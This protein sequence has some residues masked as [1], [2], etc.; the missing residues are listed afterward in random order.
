VIRNDARQFV[1]KA[2]DF[3]QGLDQWIGAFPQEAQQAGFARASLLRQ[4]MSLGSIQRALRWG[5]SVGLYGESQCG[6]S[7]LVSR[8]ASGLG[9]GS[10]K[11]GSLLIQDPTPPA[12]RAAQPWHTPGTDGIEFASWIDPSGGKEATGIVCRFTRTSLA[13]VEPGHF[14]VELMSH[15]ELASSL[16]LG[17]DAEIKESGVEGRA[18][19][20]A[21]TLKRLKAQPREP[22]TGGTMGE[23]L[24]A[25]DFLNK[26]EILG[27]HA[28]FR[29]LDNGNDGWDDFARDC[30]SERRRPRFSGQADESDL[31]EFVGLLWD[32]V[33][34][35]TRLW[36]KLYSDLRLVR[37]MRS[38]SV[39]A[40]FVCK[41]QPKDGKRMSIVSVDWMRKVF[42]DGCASCVVRGRPLGARDPI[43]VTLTCAS[44]VALAR[45]IVFPVGSG[46]CPESEIIDVLD[47]PGAR[48]ETKNLDFEAYREQPAELKRIAV[49]A[50]LRGK[51]NR[52]FGAG[53]EYYDATALCLAV[54]GIGNLEAPKPVIRSLRRWLEREGWRPS[55]DGVEEEGNRFS[56]REARFEPP[57]VVAMTKSDVVALNGADNFKN[58]LEDMKRIYCAEL[59][60]MENWYEGNPFSNIHWVHNPEAPG[61]AKL[62]ELGQERRESTITRCLEL[63]DFNKHVKHPESKLRALLES[64]A[65]DVENLFA[66]IRARVDSDARTVRLASKALDLLQ[67]LVELAN[68]N[69]IGLG[70]L[71][72]ANE[73]LKRAKQHVDALR[74]AL[75]KTQSVSDFLRA[76]EMPSAAVERAF[77]RASQI[78]AGEDQDE[79]GVVAFDAFYGQLCEAFVARFDKE[80]GRD[81]GWLRELK[82]VDEAGRT[83]KLAE[84]QSR[85]RQMPSAPWFRDAMEKGTNHLIK[86]HDPNNIPIEALGSI[87]SMVWNRSMV[88]LGD[89][90]KAPMRPDASPPRLRDRNAASEFILAHWDI[91]LPLAY[92]SLVDP[93]K[94]TLP[95]NRALGELRRELL[96]EV[97]KF[98]PQVRELAERSGSWATI[99]TRLDD[100]HGKL[101]DD[102]TEGDA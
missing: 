13:E 76:L 102:Q 21:K 10:S 14:I 99:Q 46:A 3:A 92:Q 34:P 20:I 51:I 35:M 93:S 95:H 96:S 57:L 19:R 33:K 50:M 70:D 64:P 9:A 17:Y 100:L 79:N 90:P 59:D 52:L 53:V 15:A 38:I 73:E 77:R 54:A 88:W 2:A 40:Q 47:Y 86:W 29:A 7:N 30:F 65:R 98:R 8:F 23:L 61:A 45:E 60:W 37:G 72:R 26:P 91:Q 87:G 16:A 85:F 55:S 25:W 66:E 43:N 32:S 69:Y 83:T 97:S 101:T 24:E 62:S 81:A 71:R 39:P 67:E 84:I 75:Q 56:K 49:E 27:G 48:A 58:K 31:D 78:A 4:R 36:R 1:L 68:A 94:R 5:P 41:D 12:Q 6:K 82:K 80:M 22:D 28:R 18:E 11:K 74:V 89:V 44:I 42:D 63:P